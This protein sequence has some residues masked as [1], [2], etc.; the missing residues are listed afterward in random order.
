MTLSLGGRAL[1]GLCSSEYSSKAL[2]CMEGR[3]RGHGEALFACSGLFDASVPTYRVLAV[4]MYVRVHTELHTRYC[5]TCVTSSRYFVEMT[6]KYGV[7]GNEYG[8]YV[9]YDM[10]S[11]VSYDTD[12]DGDGSTVPAPV[13]ER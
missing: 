2:R 13:H 6:W 9:K 7:F 12:M 3:F 10:Q 4:L 8:G 5:C 1:H 11:N